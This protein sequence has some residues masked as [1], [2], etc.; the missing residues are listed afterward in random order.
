MLVDVDNISMKYTP[1][2]A[3]LKKN[4]MLV[5]MPPDCRGLSP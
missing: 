3:S 1:A 5:K 4:E 2:C